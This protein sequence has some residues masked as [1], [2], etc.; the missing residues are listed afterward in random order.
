MVVGESTECITVRT[1]E[2][3]PIEDHALP[4]APE[5]GCRAAH[6]FQCLG[7]GAQA[8]TQP[9]AVGR[10]QYQ[11]MVPGRVVRNGGLPGAG[12]THDRDEHRLAPTRDADCYV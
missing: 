3:N 2:M 12:K 7:T 6:Q 11:W 10:H 1:A 5:P 8:I 4:V 9:D